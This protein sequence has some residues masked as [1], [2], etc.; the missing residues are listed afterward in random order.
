M[1]DIVFS[2]CK[3]DPDVLLRQAFKSNG[4]ECYQFVLFYKDEILAIMKEPET[5]LH[6]ELGKRFILKEKSIGAPE[7]HLGNKVLLA[8]LENGVKCWS[9]SSSKCVQVAVKNVDD[10][11]AI[12]NLGSPLKAKS[13]LPS[14]Y[15]PEA[16]VTPELVSTKASYGQ[17]L[18]GVLR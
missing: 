2:S 11:Q 9:F 16:D 5:F 4:A 18:I 13:P 17:S 15:R 8:T 1:E 7:Q 14:N 12:A 3:A 10:Y 6:E